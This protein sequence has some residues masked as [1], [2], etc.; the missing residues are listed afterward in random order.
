PQTVARIPA[1]P[2]TADNAAAAAYRTGKLQIVPSRPGSS[3]KGAIVA[4]VISMDGCIGVLSAGLRGGGETSDR[5]PAIAAILA[6]PLAGG[7]AAPPS[8]DAGRASGA[9]SG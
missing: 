6:A 3:V 1:V 2:Y 8:Q 7:V 5:T 9:A 4:P